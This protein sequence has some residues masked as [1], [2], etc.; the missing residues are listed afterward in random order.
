MKN[1]YLFRSLV[2]FF[3]I[4]QIACTPFIKIN[5]NLEKVDLSQ[6]PTEQVRKPQFTETFELTS[7]KGVIEKEIYQL[8]QKKEFGSI[9]EVASIAREKKERL[10]G[11]YWKID[12]IYA[13]LTNIYSIDSK[14]EVTDEM[15]KN[16]IN[17]LKE[18]KEISPKSITVRVALAE[19]YVNYG[20]FVRGTGFAYSVSDEAYAFLHEQLDFAERELLDAD[21]L[22]L[23][24]PRG[25]IEQCFG[26]QWQKVGQTINMKSCLK[27]QLRVSQTMFNFISLNPRHYFQNGEAKK[28][29]GES[30][31]NL[32][33][34]NYLI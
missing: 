30:L 24:C 25:D 6:K 7:K 29:T 17:L 18:W 19:S 34:K 27:K 22:G 14:K 20:W 32:F 15:W 8:S 33:P 13:A 26:L 21:G 4:M 10:L 11:G 9:E 28:V 5:G 16:H 31:S 2:I 23:N 1:I 12:S 3:V